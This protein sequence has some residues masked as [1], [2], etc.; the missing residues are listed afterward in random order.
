MEIIK[1]DYLSGDVC[2]IGIDEIDSFFENNYPMGLSNSGV[3]SFLKALKIPVKYFLKQPH[4]TKIELLQN[5][6]NSMAKDKCLILLTRNNVVEYVTLNDDLVMGDL[7]E[8]TPVNNSWIFLEEDLTAGYIRYF[9]PTSNVLDEDN[10]NLGIFLEYP[11]LFSKPMISNAGFYKINKADTS[12]NYELVIPNTKIKLKSDQLP[13]TEHNTYFL[14]L[15]EA[16]KKDNLET[17]ITFLE[18]IQTDSDSCIS[19]LLSFEKD[20]LI[21]KT[22]SSKV[23][24]YI[25]KESIP[26]FSVLELVDLMTSFI[27]DLKAHSTKLKYKTDILNSV[28][29]VNHRL[30]NINYINDFNEGY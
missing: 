29:T 25:D 9:M 12:L 24:K 21:S 11:I 3:D 18:G 10:Y 22:I 17:I 19:L 23:R 7:I 8:R 16:L 5:Q 30:P 13:S 4:D 14:D 2:K 26:L 15:L 28:L 27:H 6:K 20:K 1:N